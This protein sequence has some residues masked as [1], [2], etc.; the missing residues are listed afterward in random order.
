MAIRPR[1]DNGWHD[2]SLVFTDLRNGRLTYGEY[3]IM[4]DEDALEM[5]RRIHAEE[6]LG[7]DALFV[8]ARELEIK[9]RKLRQEAI[10]W[11][12]S[13]DLFQVNKWAKTKGLC[14][15]TPFLEQGEKE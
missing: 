10:K 11:Q 7:V 3:A 13:L 9:A 5:E 1:T 15:P 8:E 4:V 14:A 12:N 6:R 2:F